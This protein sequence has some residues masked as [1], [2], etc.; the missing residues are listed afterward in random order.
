MTDEDRALFVRLPARAAE[1]LERA[2]FERKLSKKDLV[3][4]LV[5]Q[6]LE[7]LNVEPGQAVVG[8]HTFRPAAEVLTLSEAAEL[9]RADESAIEQLAESGELPG[10]KLGEDWRFSREAVLAWLAQR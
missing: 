7:P 2:A 1:K 8:R 6:H 3:Y 4:R 10:R 5:D 9:L